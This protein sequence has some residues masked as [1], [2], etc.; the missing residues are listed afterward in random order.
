MY[1]RTMALFMLGI[2]S[3]STANPTPET[4]ALRLSVSDLCETD[5]PT[6]LSSQIRCFNTIY[7]SGILYSPTSNGLFSYG[8]SG[9]HESKRLPHDFLIID[10]SGFLPLTF[11]LTLIMQQGGITGSEAAAVTNILTKSCEKFLV[12]MRA[13]T[14][15]S[16]I[17]SRAI[18]ATMSESQKLVALL[19]NIAIYRP[20]ED[21]NI[22]FIGNADRKNRYARNLE[23]GVE[24]KIIASIKSIQNSIG[25]LNIPVAA[26]NS[27]DRILCSFSKNC[28]HPAA[29][30]ICSTHGISAQ[31]ILLSIATCEENEEVSRY[32][33]RLKDETSK[34][35]AE[36]TR[37]KKNAY[38]KL[39]I[40]IND[41]S[42]VI[43]CQ[44]R[45]VPSLK[46]C[47]PL[48]SKDFPAITANP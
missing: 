9:L 38:T 34:T 40:Y 21:T 22:F 2:A 47:A 30:S 43:P 19:K 11:I 17:Q 26:L 48:D 29:F 16:A 4:S 23:N 25:N 35:Y 27:S 18:D 46:T 3:A 7:V 1:K 10:E 6:E 20:V 37:N 14:D 28:Y 15:L 12:L 44:V 42:R 36:D 32:L 13:R 24:A 5:L 33:Q 31:M 45:R 41:V 39:E 8:L